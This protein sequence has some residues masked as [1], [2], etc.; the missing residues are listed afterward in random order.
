M[1][2]ELHT[3]DNGR[4]MVVNWD[5]VAWVTSIQPNDPK[6]IPTMTAVIMTNGATL[7]VREST[8]EVSRLLKAAEW[9]TRKLTAIGGGKDDA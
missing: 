9:P 8:E 1:N 7:T 3:A 4:L 6:A 2:L 5:Q